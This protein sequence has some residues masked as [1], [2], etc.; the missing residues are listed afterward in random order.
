M[1]KRFKIACFATVAT[2]IMIM[3]GLTATVAIADGATTN[4]NSRDD[5]ANCKTIGCIKCIYAGKTNCT[6]TEPIKV[7]EDTDKGAG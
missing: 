1:S 5:A 6:G 2:S 7:P 3:L 4:T